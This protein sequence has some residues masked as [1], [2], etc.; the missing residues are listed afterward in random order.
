MPVTRRELVISASCLALVAAIGLPMPAHAEDD[1]DMA[2][3]LEPSPLGDIALGKK[4]APVTIVEYASMTCGHCGHFTNDVLP[5][6][7][8]KYIDTGKVRY[9]LRDF[10]LDNVAA[11]ITLLARCQGGEKYYPM[12][13]MFFQQQKNWIT[14][15]DMK[16]AIFN[17]AKQAGFTQ[18]SFEAC[19]GDQKL[20]D[21]VQAVRDRAA[22]EFGVNSTPTFFINGERIVGALPAEE[23]TKIIDKHLQA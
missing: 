9:I 19:I 6:V 21:E 4:D 12:V 22:K 3:V 14:A 10:P 11:A 17:L 2:K 23:F 1:V 18:E 5:I 20:L 13:E 16:G 8:E 7:K 15:K